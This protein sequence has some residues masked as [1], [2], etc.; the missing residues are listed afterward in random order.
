MIEVVESGDLTIRVKEYNDSVKL[1][2]GQPPILLKEE[3]FL[4]SRAVINDNS[5]VLVAKV[6][7]HPT[8]GDIIIIENDLALHVRSMQIWLNVLHGLAFTEEAFKVDIGELWHIAVPDPLTKR[9]TLANIVIGRG[10]QIR[11][12]Y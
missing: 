2:S 5:K 10:G 11:V 7:Y 9:S 4:V 1:A 3:D 12:Q 8:A 6:K